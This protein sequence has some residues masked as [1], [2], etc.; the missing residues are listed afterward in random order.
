MHS[1]SLDERAG[2][3]E[4]FLGCTGAAERLAKGFHYN[5]ALVAADFRA[6]APADDDELLE[7]YRS[8]TA[9]IWELSA[10]HLEVGF[11]YGGM[12]DGIAARFAE[13]AFV[14]ALGDGIGDL[15]IALRD[16]GMNA[17][18][19][20]LKGS[21][22]AAFARTRHETRY[23][24]NGLDALWTADWDPELG[25]ECW[26]GI[27]ALD[28]MEHLINVEDWV[29]AVHT[30]LVPGGRFMA[31][32][33]FAIGDDDHEGSIPMHLVRNNHFEHDW[34]RLLTAVGFDHEIA[35]WW[36]KR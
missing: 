12:C 23:G 10:Y 15:T 13:G 24:Q 21:L 6:A 4:A 26:D 11:N 29:R 14:L 32:N 28:F 19:H 17:H 34:A 30:A 3:I 35:E 22:T 18:Y 20:D 16:A 27:I 8:T 2:E 36:V 1:P 9:Y 25:E 33:A 5:H 31:L 7:W